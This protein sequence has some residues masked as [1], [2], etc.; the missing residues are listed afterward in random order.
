MTALRPLLVPCATLLLACGPKEAPA[1]DGSAPSPET[2]AATGATGTPADPP[3]TETVAAPAQVDPEKVAAKRA[4]ASSRM[5]GA[6]P[7]AVKQTRGSMLEQLNEGRKL[8]KGGDLAAGVAAYNALLKIDPNYGPALGELGW[9]E[10]QQEKY[11]LAEAHTRHALALAPDDRRRGIFHYNLGRI[12]EAR[13]DKDAAIDA[14][15]LSLHF[16]PNETVK[17]RLAEIGTVVDAEGN[18][19]QHSAVTDYEAK[20]GD[21]AAPKPTKLSVFALGLP[22]PEAACELA[23]KDCV[24]PDAECEFIA[25]GD[26]ATA[27]W[28]R[29]AAADGAMMTCDFPLVKTA[30]GWTLFEATWVGQWGSEID[31]A[32][33]GIVTQVENNAA[34][35]FF[36][37]AYQDHTYE[38]AWGWDDLDEDE[39]LP[40]IDN[41]DSEGLVI[42]R[43]EPVS[44][45][46]PILTKMRADIDGESLS[47]EAKVTLDGDVVVIAD[48]KSEGKVVM[49]VRESVWDPAQPLPAG[50]YRLS[51]LK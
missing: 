2:P 50:R 24:G 10:F 5:S 20:F 43:R 45:T 25:H 15:A 37:F 9:A 3:S 29:V 34:G 23:K 40:P 39:E 38:R 26:A 11:A 4:E 27:T 42:C 48:V 1:G 31:Q 17:S 7:D 49:G 46:S 44:C 51:E 35:E 13:G 14:Y 33:D 22:T 28:G 18:A 12:H 41:H 21:Q 47:Y 16:R 8:V 6:S 32:L 30:E 36:V 19:Y